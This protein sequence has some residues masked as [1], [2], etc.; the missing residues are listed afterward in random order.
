VNQ[1]RVDLDQN[2]FAVIPDVLSR[3]EVKHLVQAISTADGD[4]AVRRRTGVYA[5][6]NLLDVVPAVAELSTSSKVIGIAR[7]VLGAD[8]TPVK[9]TL[10]DKT[11]DANW[12]VPW[13]QDLTV[14]V[15]ERIEADG[16]GPWT[17][18]AGVVNV[19]PPISVLERMLTIRIHL[20]DCDERNG[21]LRVLPRT[22]T[23]GRLTAVQIASAHEEITSV[24]CT[25]VAGG[26]VLMK[27]LLL[28]AS[29][30]AL[31]PRHRRVIHLDFAAVHLPGGLSWFTD[32]DRADLTIT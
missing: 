4:D 5:I 19:Q 6:R 27:P 9:G 13:H 31:D 32:R 30:P 8:A 29:S 17:V 16:Y 22:H 25:V 1:L 3:E 14:C 21:V 15:N 18:K 23:Y 26:G 24:N 28:H 7:E 12:L 10:F 20:D 2:G 11:P